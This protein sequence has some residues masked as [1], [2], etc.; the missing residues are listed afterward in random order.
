[1]RCPGADNRPPSGLVHLFAG[2][3]I[4]IA[5]HQEPHLQVKHAESALFAT[6]YRTPGATRQDDSFSVEREMQRDVICD[7]LRISMAR[8]RIGSLSR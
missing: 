2:D 5:E 8:M 4:A 7:A 6:Q 1:M 3:T